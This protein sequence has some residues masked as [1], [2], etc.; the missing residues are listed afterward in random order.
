MDLQGSIQP[1]LGI[2]FSRGHFMSGGPFTLEEV[3]H[4]GGSPTTR[5]LTSNG[6]HTTKEL[7]CTSATH[8]MHTVH[9]QGASH[10]LKLPCSPHP[11]QFRPQRAIWCLCNP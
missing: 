3:V 5:Q 2:P 10:Y 7:G 8:T 6:M 9:V 4:L 11:H 1:N